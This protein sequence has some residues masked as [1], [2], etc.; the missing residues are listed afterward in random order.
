ML[1][2][3]L[4]ALL[5]A[6]LLSLALHGVLLAWFGPWETPSLPVPAIL[7]A[8]LRAGTSVPRP[9][10]IAQPQQQR[11]VQAPRVHSRQQASAAS[12]KRLELAPRTAPSAERPVLPFRAPASGEAEEAV[13]GATVA[14]GSPPDPAPPATVG[15][16]DVLR[17]FRM[18]LARAARAARH[19]PAMA[20]ERGQEGVVRLRLS[21]RQGMA[22]PRIS[23]Q[24]GSGHPLLDEAA[25]EMLRQALAA[26]P[27]PRELPAF[28]FVLPVEFSL[29]PS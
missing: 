22:S 9:G 10:P 20:R 16:P 17:E 7:Q 19:Y 1:P 5:K 6:L 29:G 3:S 21:W 8:Q 25:Q 24:Q 4:R 2:A 23:L 14:S 18:A 13:P 26:T 15:D 11:S 12:S 27:L 28:D